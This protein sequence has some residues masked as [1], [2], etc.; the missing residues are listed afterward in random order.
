MTASASAHDN[1]MAHSHSQTLSSRILT[2]ISIFLLIALA[3]YA[4]GPASDQI[5]PENPVKL[6]NVKFPRI[7]SAH[8]TPIKSHQKLNVKVAIVGVKTAEMTPHNRMTR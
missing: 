8:F 7:S 6:S 2:G 3:L 1:P 4:L 5:P